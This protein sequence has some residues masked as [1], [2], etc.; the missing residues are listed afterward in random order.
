MR[1]RINVRTRN[2]SR[3]RLRVAPD[4]ALP[5]VIL[6][7]SNSHNFESSL[8]NHHVWASVPLSPRDNSKRIKNYP[9]MLNLNPPLGTNTLIEHSIR[10]LPPRDLIQ[11]ESV[12][13]FVSWLRCHAKC[14]LANSTVTFHH[15]GVQIIA[16]RPRGE[17][18]PC[19]P[20]Q[21][22]FSG[23]KTSSND[24]YVLLCHG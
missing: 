22:L 12:L 6:L 23:E 19:C 24:V 18:C 1:R 16:V 5:L 7:S 8:F 2:T 3:S 10:F 17:W 4:A 9:N 13:S 11:A 21:I 15:C 14:L 20:N